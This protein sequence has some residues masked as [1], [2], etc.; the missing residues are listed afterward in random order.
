MTK[1]TDV[2]S[3]GGESKLQATATTVL[4]IPSRHPVRSRSS[5]NRGEDAPPL[6]PRPSGNSSRQQVTVPLPF[7]FDIRRLR[8]SGSQANNEVVPEEAG[9]STSPPR[10]EGRLAE[11]IA[12]GRADAMRSEEDAAEKAVRWRMACRWQAEHLAD[13]RRSEEDVAEKAPR[14]QMVCRWQAKRIVSCRGETSKRAV[15]P[16]YCKKKC[17]YR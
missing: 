17:P 6:Q 3:G 8:H 10:N 5:A 11:V 16:Y 13:A 1:K 12:E 4:P 9:P 7:S 15:K 14:W 2:T